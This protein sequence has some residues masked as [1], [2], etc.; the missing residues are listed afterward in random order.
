MRK[1]TKLPTRK[2]S[3]PAGTAV[4]L[5]GRPGTRDLSENQLDQVQG[6]SANTTTA[7]VGGIFLRR[8][9]GARTSTVQG[10]GFFQVQEEG[11]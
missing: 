11:G 10:G 3:E 8:D 4:E 1:N 7:H 5:P 6:G 2:I 9:E